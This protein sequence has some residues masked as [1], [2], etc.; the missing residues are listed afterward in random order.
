MFA[1][2][3]CELRVAPGVYYESYMCMY[4]YLQVTASSISSLAGR[5][6]TSYEYI[7]STLPVASRPTLSTHPRRSNA[8]GR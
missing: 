8:R 5:L 1:Y 3:C 6:E 4:G 7:L 2:Y